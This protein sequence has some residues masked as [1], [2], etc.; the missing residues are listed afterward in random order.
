MRLQETVLTCLPSHRK[1]K[2]T[3]SDG[4]LAAEDSFENSQ[5]CESGQRSHTAN[6]NKRG[7]PISVQNYAQ[8][9]ARGLRESLRGLELISFERQNRAW[10]AT[11]ISR[12]LN[13]YGFKFRNL[14]VPMEL[15]RNGGDVLSRTWRAPCWLRCR[16]FSLHRPKKDLQ[17]IAIGMTRSEKLHSTNSKRTAYSSTDPAPQLCLSTIYNCL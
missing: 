10:R 17:I 5:H 3:K 13:S 11:S 6:H 16:R 1:R 12:S 9:K 4:K 7:E 15:G 2:G 8:S 14:T